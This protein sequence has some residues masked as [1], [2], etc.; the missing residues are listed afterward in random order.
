MVVE[1]IS[2]LV[3]LLAIVAVFLRA[4]KRSYALSILPLFF[5][6]GAH[7]AAT[8][9]LL[10]VRKAAPDS[11]W[12]DLARIAATLIGLI[13]SCIML[14]VLSVRMKSKR[15]RLTYVVLC[16]IFLLAL[17]WMLVANALTAEFAL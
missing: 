1:C 3:I 7:L 12:F 5:V 14:G 15:R 10:L 11:D 13:C 17:T 8:A 16:G 4:H 6:P 9:V 2:I